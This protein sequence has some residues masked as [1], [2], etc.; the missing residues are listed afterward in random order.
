MHGSWQA[1]AFIAPAAT[2]ECWLSEHCWPRSS[3]GA[4]AGAG[5]NNGLAATTGGSCLHS[6][7]HVRLQLE[8][9]A[10]DGNG[11]RLAAWRAW[12]AS[13]ILARGTGTC[14]S[15]L[16]AHPERPHCAD[17]LELCHGCTEEDQQRAAA[18][19]QL[20]L[21]LRALRPCAA[22]CACLMLHLAAPL[23][24]LLHCA[25][26]STAPA[27][28]LCWLLTALCW[29]LHCWLRDHVRCGPGARTSS[30]EADEEAL[31]SS[32]LGYIA[33]QP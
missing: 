29:L 9:P 14:G 21:Q 3:S 8:E 2:E 12:V 10:L 15:C 11:L 16:H 28:A 18:T 26:C 7:A 30:A 32:N 5:D 33:T 19:V 24:R 4:A 25:G 17:C 6:S 1:P 22:A 20:Q 23:C 27:A 13:C 31:E